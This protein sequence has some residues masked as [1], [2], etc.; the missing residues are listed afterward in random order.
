MTCWLTKEHWEAA[1]GLVTEGCI[2]VSDHMLIMISILSVQVEPLEMLCAE[3]VY[4]LSPWARDLKAEES[5][6]SDVHFQD[7]KFILNSVLP[8]ISFGA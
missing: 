8:V 1:P 3:A 4:A 6:A 2:V 5:L 7:I